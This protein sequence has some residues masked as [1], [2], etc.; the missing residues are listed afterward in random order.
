MLFIYRLAQVTLDA[1]VQR[2]SPVNVI[3]KRSHEN[4]RDRVA[5]VDKASV[6]FETRHGRHMDVGDQAGCFDEAR[7]GEKFGCR[8]ER[9]GRMAER[10]QESAHGLTTEPVII[11]DRNQYLFHHAA[12]GHSPDPPCGQ[13]T[14]PTLCMELPDV[15]ENATSAMP[16]LRKLW[17][18]LTITAKLGRQG[19]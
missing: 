5:Q 8:R 14:M 18:I 7:G 17:L 16:M 15:G 19:L 13:P 4:C 3:G 2:A 9:V 12:Y 6:E 11:D 1:V 10:S